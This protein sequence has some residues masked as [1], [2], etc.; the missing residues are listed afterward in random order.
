MWSKYQNSCNRYSF[1]C[2]TEFCKKEKQIIS[3]T[4]TLQCTGRQAGESTRLLASLRS[5]HSD[6]ISKEQR[7]KYGENT[8]RQTLSNQIFTSTIDRTLEPLKLSKFSF[9]QHPIWIFVPIS[10]PFISTIF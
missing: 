3:T 6:F 10:V 9:E 7:Q 8:A 5:Q 4:S 2:K 1:G